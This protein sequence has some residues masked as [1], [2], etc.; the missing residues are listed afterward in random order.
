MPVVSSTYWNMIYGNTPQEIKRDEEGMQTLRNLAKNM[1][2]LIKCVQA[3]KDS[4]IAP[5][6]QLYKINTV[7]GKFA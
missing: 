2:W 7:Y 5:P 3:G 4:G 1:A 6:H